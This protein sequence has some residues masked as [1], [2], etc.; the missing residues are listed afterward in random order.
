MDISVIVVD[1]SGAQLSSMQLGDISEEK[2]NK[3]LK[4]VRRAF[5]QNQAYDFGSLV[6]GE[7]RKY[8]HAVPNK[9]M[10]AAYMYG[11]RTGRKFTCQALSTG[12][13]RITRTA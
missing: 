7:T 12:A 5:N 6:V 10:P 1:K 3:A 9:I 2:L 13:V 8:G 4:T 11:R